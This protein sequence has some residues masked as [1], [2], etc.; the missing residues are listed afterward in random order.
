MEAF[1]LEIRNVHFWAVLSSGALLLLRGT[2]LNLLG[3]GWALGWPLRYLS[4]VVDTVLLT[5]ALMLTTIIRQFPFI[6][7]WL[8]VKVLLL[9]PYLVLGYLALRAKSRRKRVVA[10]LGAGAAFGFIYTVA[11][12]HQPLGLFA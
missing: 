6:D 8:T 7:S 9:A 3:A 1:Y 11:R 12:A 2:A 10:L 4:W 5:S